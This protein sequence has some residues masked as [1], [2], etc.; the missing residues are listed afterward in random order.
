[1]SDGFHTKNPN[2][3]YK[4]YFSNMD[5]NGNTDIQKNEIF[6]IKTDA[7]F[8]KVALNI[9]H[10]QAS[11]NL[12]YSEY[13]R[14]LGLDCNAVTSS[15]EIPFLPIV[16]F[17]NFKIL[18]GNSDVQ[19][20]FSSS[21]TTGNTTSKNHIT[22]IS[23]YQQSFREGFELFYGPV[24]DYCILALLP[25][26]LENDTSSLVFMADD[27]I[28]RSKH[29][30]SGFYLDNKEELLLKLGDLEE[31]NQK[32]ILLGVSYALLDVV[33]KNK[34]QLKNTIV[35]E[36]GGMK[37][38]RREMIR[39]ELH[40]TLSEGFGVKNIHSEYGMTELLS[41]AYSKGNGL[42]LTP[43]WMKILI[44]DT[45]D[46]L[47]I[48]GFENTGGIN[49]IDLANINSCAFIATEDLGKAHINGS[50]EVL[51]RFDNSNIR[52]CNLMNI[53]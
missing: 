18:S 24:E 5:I 4:K 42:F 36:T 35:M 20:I 12:V 16:F 29:K 53:D 27:L 47:S 45:Q 31:K 21:G 32:V 6:N 52:G 33:S 3:K 17:K 11:N 51:G 8:E 23:L 7:D 44:R 34:M 22:D 28:K 2:N 10:Y 26:Y 40:H 41:Q 30:D 1:M 48:I 13:L 50:F 37:G 39:E 43:P 9:F 15:K 19:R 14:T 38:R 25:S 46:P 49:V